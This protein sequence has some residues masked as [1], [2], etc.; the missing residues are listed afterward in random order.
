MIKA[1]EL[2]PLV[3]KVSVLKNRKRAEDIF[4]YVMNGC[5]DVDSASMAQSASLKIFNV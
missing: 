1:D 5:D 2:T 4:A 3:E